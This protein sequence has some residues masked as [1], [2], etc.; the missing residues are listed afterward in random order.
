MGKTKKPGKGARQQT[1]K[2]MGKGTTKSF[3]NQFHTIKKAFSGTPATML[4]VSHQTGI[5]R[6]NICRYV[7]TMKKQNQIVLIGFGLCQISG[8]KAGFY[9]TKKG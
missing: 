3:S 4:M 1:Q 8:F 7:A 2:D 5:E 6:A 9:S